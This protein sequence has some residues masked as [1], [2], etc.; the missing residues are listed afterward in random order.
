MYMKI[1]GC[2]TSEAFEHPG[3]TYVNE[4]LVVDNGQF[5]VQA[6]SELLYISRLLQVMR[7]FRETNAVFQQFCQS[8]AFTPLDLSTSHTF[9]MGSQGTSRTCLVPT[10]F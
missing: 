10:V 2:Q 1:S 8:M 7:L 4:L 5:M 9:S 6:F 3:I